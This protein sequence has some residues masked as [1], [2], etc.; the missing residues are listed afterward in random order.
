MRPYGIVDLVKSG[1]VAMAKD[2]KAKDPRA[3]NPAR[4]NL[5]SA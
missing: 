4:T 1:R 2:L 5:R 3:A